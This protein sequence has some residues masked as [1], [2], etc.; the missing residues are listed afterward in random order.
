MI[1]YR[2]KSW[3]Q[4]TCKRVP[5][6]FQV[7]NIPFYISRVER[8]QRNT[9]WSFKGTLARVFFRREGRPFHSQLSEC[10]IDTT[11]NQQKHD[12]F[13]TKKRRGTEK[14]RRGKPPDREGKRRNYFYAPQ[15]LIVHSLKKTAPQK[16]EWILPV[17]VNGK[18]QERTER[19]GKFKWIQFM[20][21][22]FFNKPF[23]LL[24]VYEWRSREMRKTFWCHKT[25][26]VRWVKQFHEWKSCL[27]LLLH[28]SKES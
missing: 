20:G 24:F 13:H 11:R 6:Q 14:K 12:N 21:D 23:S 18:Q 5:I 15:N 17:V 22:S 27:F 28:G 26:G 4:R 3:I 9:W 10:L 2:E 25:C 16:D 1:N 8:W 19:K 7:I